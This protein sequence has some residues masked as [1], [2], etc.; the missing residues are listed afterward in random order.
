VTAGQYSGTQIL[1]YSGTQVLKYSGTQVLK[2][3]GTQVLRY[4]STQ[5]LKYSS[6]QVLRYSSTQVLTKLYQ[7]TRV[8]EYRRR[9]AADRVR[10]PSNVPIL[11]PDSGI[12][13]AV[14][15]L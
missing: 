2:Y 3:S 6:T 15:R 5:V 9:G 10:V 8:P 1:G 13:G 4:S 14:S 11:T 7:S 12:L